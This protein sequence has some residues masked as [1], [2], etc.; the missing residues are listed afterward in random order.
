MSIRKNAI[1]SIRIGME[2]FH[3]EKEGRHISAVRNIVAGLLLLYKEKLRLLS[4]EGDPELL[5]KQYVLP[6]LDADGNLFFVGRD[7]KTVDVQQIKKRFEGLNVHVD[8]K[9]FDD[10]NKIRNDIEHYYTSES[11]DAIREALS[12]SLLLIRN[13]ITKNL[14]E[15]PLELLGSECW[16]SLLKVAK[17]YKKEEKECKATLEAVDW[18]HEMQ[19]KCIRDIRCSKCGSSLIRTDHEGKYTPSMDFRCASCGNKFAAEDAMEACV[20]EYFW[21]DPY[22]AMKEDEEPRYGTCPNCQKETFIL[23]DDIC[24]ACESSRNYKECEGCGASL[25]LDEQDL[26]GFCTFCDYGMNRVRDE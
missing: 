23:A 26:G 17:V 6:K 2:D 9:C 25:K 16:N 15:D 21:I 7:R 22:I 8:W 13:F 11:R 24:L 10:I 18:K 4:P 20:A 3:S 19:S 14:H 12:K 1:D 5:I